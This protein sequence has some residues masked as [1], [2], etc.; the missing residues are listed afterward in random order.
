M[1][2]FLLGYGLVVSLMDK[3]ESLLIAAF[4]PELAGLDGVSPKGWSIA[5]TGVGAIAAAVAVAR[6]LEEMR[7]QRVLFIGTCG[8]YGKGLGIGDCIA[9]S[10]VIA[11]S[12]SEIQCRA[13]GPA[14]ETTQWHPTWE[15]NLPKAKVAATPAIT[16]NTEDAALLAQVADV[17]HLELSGVFAACHIARVP[18]AAALAVSN[19]AGFDAH[20]EWLDNHEQVCRR[21]VAILVEMGIILR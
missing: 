7:P 15:L 6:A 1:Q 3:P 16:S 14:L 13:F 2:C 18:V 20:A 21:L 10:E 17:E 4:A 11:A 8:A 19:R 5:T 9:A 12:V